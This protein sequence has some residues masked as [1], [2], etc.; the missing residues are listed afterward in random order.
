MFDYLVGFVDGEVESS[1]ELP[2][3]PGLIKIELVI[4]LHVSWHE[5]N[6]QTHCTN[7]N[8]KSVQKSFP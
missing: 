6:D 1:Y 8:E 2:I 7:E 5:V 3:F 4:E